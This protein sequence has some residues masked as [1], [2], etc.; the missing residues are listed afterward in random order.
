MAAR[1]WFAST[2]LRTE[3]LMLPVPVM[4]VDQTEV[5]VAFAASVALPVAPGEGVGV[6][7]AGEPVSVP[8]PSV[9]VSV[10]V[11]EPVGEPVSVAVPVPVSVAVAVPVPPSVID[12]AGSTYASV[13][14]SAGAAVFCAPSPPCVGAGS[15][16]GGPV[17]S[18]VT[19]VV[20]SPSEP[21][22]PTACVVAGASVGR[23][24]IS[25]MVTVRW[26]VVSAAVRLRRAR[27]RVGVERCM[28]GVGFGDG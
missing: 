23:Y 14:P 13:V 17:I 7:V 9:P 21:T 24:L 25:V 12:M 15:V 27:A 18:I 1:V 6:A 22:W 16:G 11:G 26:A 19:K 8:F 28:L 2:E 10:P 3:R 4:S 20:M 5:S